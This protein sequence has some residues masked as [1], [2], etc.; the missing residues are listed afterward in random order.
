MHNL[1]KKIYKTISS[2]KKY[3]DIK[4]DLTTFYWSRKDK[5][6]MSKIIENFTSEGDVIFDPF[7]GSGPILFSLDQSNKNLHFVGSEIN[8]M[9][10]AFVKFNL[11]DLNLD[12]LDYIKRNFLTFYE[13]YKNLYE[14]E[15]PLLNDEKIL[16]SKIILDKHEEGYIPKKF[17]F[18]GKEKLFIDRA[19]ENLFKK[20]KLSYQN[21]CLKLEKYK[22]I[23]DIDLLPNSRIAIKKGMRMSHLFNSINFHVLN[24]YSKEFK[25]NDVM[26]TFLASVLHLCR[27]TD[28]KSQSQFPFWVPKKD[29][30]ER[31]V[32]TLL[33]KR[34]EKVCKEKN[35][36]TLEL[37]LVTNFKTFKKKKKSVYLLSKPCQTITEKDLPDKAV[38]I[39]ITDPPYFDQVAYS[40]YLKIWEFFCDY[41]SQLKNELIY[42]N[43]EVE[44]SNK[45][46]YLENL[47]HCFS[48]VAKKLKDNG[49]S[50]IF[51]KDSKPQ[52]IDLFIKQ[53]EKCGL[54]FIK[55]C[56]LEKK[57]YTYKQNTT[58]NTTVGGECLFFFKKCSI[59][60][61]KITKKFENKNQI[62]KEIE[63]VTLNF[64]KKNYAKNDEASLGELYDSGLILRLYDEN[65]LKYITNSKQIVSILESNLLKSKNR[66]YK[67]DTRKIER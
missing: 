33:K 66:K 9:P 40:E 67:I 18:E 19:D 58:Q 54:K 38:D 24:E 50:I 30:V 26:I 11:T 32:L 34:I 10:L 28:L 37:E 6:I 64:L 48:L 49:L 27:L 44:A 53:M 7:L 65:L 15:N 23:Y 1:D 21:R 51:F 4:K 29:A 36:N 47:Y 12:Q 14:Y 41:K 22:K 45:E 56:H 20:L 55:T 2:D 62:N 60:T 3:T 57:K 63:K 16:I 8:E 52:N 35:D 43:R 13:K 46:N 17:I 31:N 5:Q 42:S 61:K 59:K 25:N 39:V